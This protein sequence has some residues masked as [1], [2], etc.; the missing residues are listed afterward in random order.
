VR[1]AGTGKEKQGPTGTLPRVAFVGNDFIRKGGKELVAWHQERARDNCELH[2]VS[3]KAVPDT[4]LRNV[5]WHGRVENNYLNQTL[6]PSMDLFVFPT[7]KDAVPIVLAEA[8]AAGVPVVTYR[9]GF[10]RDM[11]DE[12]KSGL[13]F[14]VDDQNGFYQSVEALLSDRDRLQRMSAHAR[15][16][17]CNRFSA[18]TV[19]TRLFD[20]LAEEGRSARQA[21]GASPRY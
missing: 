1:S 3:S 12:G 2:I 17:A 11:L 10:L 14:D 15:S 6:L 21:A 19:L 5:V 20:R 16:W 8:Q 4:N 13:S 9:V 18:E 7:R